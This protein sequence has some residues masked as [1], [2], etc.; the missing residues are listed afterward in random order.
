MPPGESGPNGLSEQRPCAGQ[1]HRSGGSSSSTA[2][3]KGR[4]VQSCAGCSAGCSAGTC[5]EDSAPKQTT[6]TPCCLWVRTWVRARVRV[7]V[8]VRHCDPPTGSRGPGHSAH[9]QRASERASVDNDGRGCASRPAARQHAP[10]HAPTRT[11]THTSAATHS[12]HYGQAPSPKP[13]PKPTRTPEPCTLHLQR[14][15]SVCVQC[16]RG[17]SCPLRLAG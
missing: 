5:A 13:K 9:Q 15:S 2:S 7:R 4:L 12:T 16:G 11:H 14:R 3:A 17:W 1:Q 8:R 10:T 6:K